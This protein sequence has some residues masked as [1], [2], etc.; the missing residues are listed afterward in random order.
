M[1]HIPAARW[2]LLVFALGIVLLV[3]VFILAYG[4]FAST[5][6]ALVQADSLPPD[7]LPP[8]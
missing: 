1:A 2:G 8:L 3:V 5:T 6:G 4:L 7:S